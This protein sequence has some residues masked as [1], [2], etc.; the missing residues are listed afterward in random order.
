[1]NKGLGIVMAT[2]ATPAAIGVLFVIL[3]L[4]GVG[5]F[6]DQDWNWVFRNVETCALVATPIALVVS[7]LTG[8]P[9]G[10]WLAKRGRTRPGAFAVLGLA[11]GALP[12]V[13]FDGS[14]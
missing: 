14:R 5:W 13:L 12:F 9:L 6:A 8:V 3:S 1:M 7:L 4:L 10:N 11:L 2:L